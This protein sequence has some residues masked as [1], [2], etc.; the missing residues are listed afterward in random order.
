MFSAVFSHDIEGVGEAAAASPWHRGLNLSVPGR[1]ALASWM[2]GG[3]WG[4]YL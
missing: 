4:V 2:H 1:V 3:V